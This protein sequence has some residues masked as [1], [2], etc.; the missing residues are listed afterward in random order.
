M[1]K[2]KNNKEELED[3]KDVISLA[4]LQMAAAANTPEP[5]RTIGLFGDLDEKK[6]KTFALVFFT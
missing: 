5:L 3:G 6:L 2:T 1:L 4:D